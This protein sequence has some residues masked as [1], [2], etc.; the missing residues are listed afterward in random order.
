MRTPA[1]PA[2]ADRLGPGARR[3]RLAR[4]LAARV[5]E[6]EHEADRG[7]PGTGVLERPAEEPERQGAR[8]L[9]PGQDR[10]EL[11]AGRP[12]GDGRPV[13]GRP[14]A[15]EERAVRAA[16]DRQGRAER[17][18]GRRRADGQRAG[19]P[20]LGRP[21]VQGEPIRGDGQ[22]PVAPDPQMPAG[23]VATDG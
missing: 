3:G 14:G 12:D 18:Q 13:V 19:P 8:G 6:R 7:P 16:P 17:R 21:D 22:E 2:C 23:E 15:R 5:A 10:R 1:L 4:F 11:L 20:A 9:V